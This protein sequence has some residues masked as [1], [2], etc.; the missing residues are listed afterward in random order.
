MKLH[1]KNLRFA[2]IIG[3]HDWEIERLRQFSMDVTLEYD[4]SKAIAGDDF[5][6][7]V[8]YGKVEQQM[9]DLARSRHWKLIETLVDAAANQIL[10]SFSPVKEVT[11]AITK[12]QAM[13][14]AESVTATLTKTR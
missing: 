3:V 9:L 2:A 8:D 11:I 5:S 1:I 6:H 12:P 10:Q 13:H 4:A 7:A 14:F